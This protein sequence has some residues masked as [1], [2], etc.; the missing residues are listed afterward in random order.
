VTAF[1]SAESLLRQHDPHAYGCIV[2]DV[3][4]PG[5]NGLQLQHA[6]EQRGNLMPIIFLTGQADVPIA[7]AEAR[8]VRFPH[9][10]WTMR[11]CSPARA[12]QRD[13]ELLARGRGAKP[14]IAAGLAD[15]ARA[16]CQPRIGRLKKQIA[17]DLGTAE[18]GT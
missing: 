7:R 17:A 14:P 12:L 4:M 10:R 11:C 15:G 5:L 6:L 8:C 13:A 3:A 1:E 16:G 18:K 2:L 9:R